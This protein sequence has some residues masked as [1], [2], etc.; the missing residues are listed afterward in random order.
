MDMEYGMPVF[1]AD[2][3]LD[4]KILSQLIPQRTWNKKPASDVGAGAP[5]PKSWL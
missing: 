2:D 1:F 4:I 3:I 5:A